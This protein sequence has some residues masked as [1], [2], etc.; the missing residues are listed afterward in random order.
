[1][2]LGGGIS[3]ETLEKC[4][5]ALAPL[6]RLVSNAVT[7]ESE[8]VLLDWQAR[9]GGEL[10]RISISR[11]ESVGSFQGWRPLMPVTQFS[12]VKR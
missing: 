6:G 3:F 5:E 7:L 10:T 4:W 2:F 12:M 11:A 9:Q 1:V 8:R